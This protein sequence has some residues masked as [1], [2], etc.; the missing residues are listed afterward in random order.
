[1]IT[2][3]LFFYRSAL[4][5]HINIYKNESELIDELSR[6]YNCLNVSITDIELWV[7]DG[8]LNAGINKQ[9]SSRD[10]SLNSQDIHRCMDEEHPRFIILSNTDYYRDSL[11]NL[12]MQI[13]NVNQ[14]CLKGGTFPELEFDSTTHN[15]NNCLQGLQS[16]NAKLC[17]WFTQKNCRLW[18]KW[19]A[20]AV[21]NEYNKHNENYI[22]NSPQILTSID[23]NQTVTYVNCEYYHSCSKSDSFRWIVKYMH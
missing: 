3:L 7:D 10:Y 20:V 14:L 23:L 15:Y 6:F 4:A 13:N 11:Q 19:I 2:S 12:E 18:S 9:N 21:C 8:Q 1:M 22:C 17:N 5:I 16:P